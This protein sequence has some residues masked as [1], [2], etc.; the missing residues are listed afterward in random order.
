M[1]A[2]A[3]DAKEANYD[4]V[5]KDEEYELPSNASFTD[6]LFH[7]YMSFEG[8]AYFN[9]SFLWCAVWCLHDLFTLVD[10]NL[11]DICAVSSTT[12]DGGSP[13]RFP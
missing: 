2:E 10:V 3:C 13:S 11:L 9:F 7:P 8:W 1:V 4:P 12:L 6:Y 5:D